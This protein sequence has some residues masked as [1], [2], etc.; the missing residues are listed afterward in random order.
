MTLASYTAS[1]ASMLVLAN[2]PVG[3]VNNIHEAT[4]QKVP[5]CL[6]EVSRTTPGIQAHRIHGTGMFAYMDGWLIFKV[7]V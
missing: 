3:A 6:P 1:L 5:V 4:S 7:N 2:Q